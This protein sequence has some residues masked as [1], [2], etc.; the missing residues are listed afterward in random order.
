MRW[1]AIKNVE[2]QCRIIEGLKEIPGVDHAALLIDYAQSPTFRPQPFLLRNG[3]VDT[4]ESRPLVAMNPVSSE[5]FDTMR[6]TLL[7]GRGFAYTDDPRRAPVAVVDD[8]F[9]RRYLLGLQAWC[10]HRS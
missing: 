5:F 1:A 6:I 10:A 3:E 7:E 8:L 9:V 4:G 2:L